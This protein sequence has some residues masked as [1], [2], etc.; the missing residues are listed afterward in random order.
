MAQQ[1]VGYYKP[2]YNF[3]V[4]FYQGQWIMRSR[5]ENDV[6]AHTFEHDDAI[7][8]WALSNREKFND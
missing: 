8:L 6:Q 4:E 1:S 3:S 7:E 2:E 5:Q